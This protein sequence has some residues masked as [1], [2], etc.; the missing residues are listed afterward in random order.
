MDN[1]SNFQ[2]N[3]RL[4]GEGQ[5]ERPVRNNYFFQHRL[6]CTSKE[7]CAKQKGKASLKIW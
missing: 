4:G 5:K 7:E 6:Q 2:E 1:V 3:V